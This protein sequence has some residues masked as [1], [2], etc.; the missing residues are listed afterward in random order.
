MLRDGAGGRPLQ[1]LFALLGAIAT[2]GNLLKASARLG[3]SYRHAWG[4]VRK[5]AKLLGGPVVT[6]RRGQAFQLTAL[7]ERLVWADRRATE[8]LSPLL[9]SFAEELMSELRPKDMRAPL[10]MH[11]GYAFV[12][13]ALAAQLQKESKSCE[14]RYV[15][16]S[17]ALSALAGGTADVAGFPVPEGE[18]DAK[19]LS[20]YGRW[21]DPRRHTL[22]Q[23]VVR[24]QGLI[25]APGNP[26]EI[27]SLADLGKRGL[28]FVN[29]QRGSGTRL[30]LEM[31]LRRAG[32]NPARIAGFD[33]TEN[34]HGAIAA[35][36]A[37]GLA[38]AG[39]GV[40]TAAR[41]FAL[42]FVPLGRERYFLAC[43]KETL[44][45]AAGKGLLATVRSRE[46]RKRLSEIPG[47]DSSNCGTPHSVEAVL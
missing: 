7:G 10:R 34:S 35:C 6:S 19:Y 9:S 31:L 21:L 14:M 18:L 26:L 38:D 29:R 46:F 42:G 22:I 3:I 47:I 33:N 13:A 28:R 12:A 17:E 39:P 32:V 45:S 23:L 37:S 2:E 5:G 15:T 4:L 1:E 41:R 8:R 16:T 44:R 36:V 24:H 27:L 30:L 43:R 40:E 20:S 11:A 25:V